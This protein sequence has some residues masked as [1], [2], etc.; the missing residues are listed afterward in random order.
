MKI[1]ELEE[2]YTLIVVV[3]ISKYDASTSSEKEV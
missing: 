1:V 3:N 2:D